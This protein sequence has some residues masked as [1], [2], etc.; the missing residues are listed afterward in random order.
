MDVVRLAARSVLLTFAV[1]LGE[2]RLE[3]PRAHREHTG[4][5]AELLDGMEAV[6]D[7]QDDIAELA[8][9]VFVWLEKSAKLHW[10]LV[11]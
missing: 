3:N 7:N 9:G 5:D 2:K 11:V 10:S 6:I 4:R 1:S 8:Y